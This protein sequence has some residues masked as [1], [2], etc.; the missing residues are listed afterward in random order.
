MR[1]T[2]VFFTSF[3]VSL[4]A[5]CSEDTARTIDGAD[6]AEAALDESLPGA[7]A[8]TRTAI[9]SLPLGLRPSG[10]HAASTSALMQSA[11]CPNGGSVTVDVLALGGGAYEGTA[12]FTACGL[13][14]IVVDGTL[15]GRVTLSPGRVDF[16]LS[17]NLDFSGTFSGA[18][19]IHSLL[20]RL[21]GG[22]LCYRADV[23]IGSLRAT[24]GTPCSPGSDAG[25]FSDAGSS[26][27]AADVGD[28]GLPNA[29]A[30]S[31]AGL[32][33]SGADAGVAADASAGDASVADSGSTD[34][35]DAGPTDS[36]PQNRIVLSDEGLPFTDYA[37][38]AFYTSDGTSV[39]RSTD[40][41]SWTTHALPVSPPGGTIFSFAAIGG[42]IVASATSD[43]FHSPDGMTWTLTNAPNLTAFS[44]R[45]LYLLDL[46]S[47]L[48]AY[49]RGGTQLSSSS[50]GLDW[51][52]LTGSGASRNSLVSDGVGF[53]SFGNNRRIQGSSDL[54]DWVELEGYQDDFP[55]GPP[56]LSWAAYE[57]G[58]LVMAACQLPG[59]QCR[60]FRSTSGGT[61]WAE[62][63][64]G[65]A[66]LD[67][68]WEIDACP[69]EFVMAVTKSLGDDV[70]LLRSPDG[71]NWTE[72]PTQLFDVAG[73]ACRDG[74]ALVTGEEL[75]AGGV[76]YRFD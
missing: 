44:N 55:S 7:I 41:L 16:D 25:V 67:T 38:G 74:V 56:Q 73:V 61:S 42:A 28:A 60:I 32:V 52:E 2:R 40:G 39:F 13:Q 76:V 63:A 70:A 1:A 5:G 51:S 29:D 71:L 33:D 35:G 10:R 3:V 15:S 26:P 17:G 53:V 62:V 6:S 14:G 75:S 57:G 20:G 22:A 9:E 19:T 23:S 43:V 27:D 58:V 69:G 31:D 59:A 68:V 46:G 34:A 47:Q 64:M 72:F 49:S 11:S 54:V 21:D 37:G 45:A 12:N 18:L 4:G 66:E 50:N 48:L 36:G 24:V 65:Q 8:T 30:G